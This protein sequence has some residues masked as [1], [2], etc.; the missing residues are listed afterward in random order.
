MAYVSKFQ[1]LIVYQK[2]RVLWQ[3]IFE[4]TKSF[5]Q[6]ERFSLTDQIRRSSRSVGAQIAEAW[7]KRRYQKHFLSKLTD[8]D[9][10]ELETQHWIGVAKDSGYISDEKAKE[11]LLQAEEIGRLLGGMMRKSAMFCN[12]SKISEVQADYFAD[13]SQTT[14]Y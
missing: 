6:E 2:A 14:E 7:G 3:T 13:Q 5:P 9:S 12:S 10:E 1:D 8:A 11:L 4:I